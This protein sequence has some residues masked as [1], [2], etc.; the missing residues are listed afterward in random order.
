MKTPQVKRVILQLRN[1][2]NQSSLLN[3]F[4]TSNFFTIKYRKKTKHFSSI[5]KIGVDLKLILV[6]C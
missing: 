2:T 3:N 1:F 4:F 5:L 6:T